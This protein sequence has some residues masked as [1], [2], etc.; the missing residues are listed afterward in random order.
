MDFEGKNV[1]VT[2]GS[3]GIGKAIVDSFLDRGAFVITT[4]TKNMSGDE[5]SDR[6]RFWQLDLLDQD[7]INAF[8]ER[9]AELGRVDVLIN[10]AGINI[11]EDIESLE[12]YHWDKVISVNLTGPMLISK[13]VIPFMKEKG[14]RIVNI[15][16]I[17]GIISKEGRVSYTSAKT[18]LVGFTRSLALDLVKY[19]ILVN[20]VCPGFTLTDLTKRSLSPGQMNKLKREI[21][22]GR[23]AGVD[24]IAKVVLFLSSDLNSYMTGQYVV[25]DGG[26]TIR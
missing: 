14:G 4:S 10:N 17:W 24:E 18:G 15:S 12:K 3:R 13:A 2:G 1:I 22:I 26:F 25:V 16:S 23:F 19:N 20:A 5:Y 9:I 7:S 8:C 11:I 6:M 21:P